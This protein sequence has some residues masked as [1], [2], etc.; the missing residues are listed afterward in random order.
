MDTP[1]PEKLGTLAEGRGLC[2]G[3]RGRSEASSGNNSWA[4]TDTLRCRIH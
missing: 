4:V 1:P 2:G 3:E